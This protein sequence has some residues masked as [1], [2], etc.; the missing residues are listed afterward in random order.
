MTEDVLLAGL[1]EREGGFTN[2][3]ADRG[4]ATNFGITARELGEW[5][6]L[7]RA[8]TVAEVKA[9]T[10]SEA[11]DIYRRRYLEPFAAVPF[12]ELRAQ[13][14]DY[15]VNCGVVTAKRALQAVLRVPVDGVLGPRTLAAL[16]TLDWRLVNNG[17]VADRVKRYVGI[18]NEDATQKV[19]LLGWA[20]RA[21]EFLI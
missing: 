14:V 8:A 4:G 21:V 5:R 19:F 7:G 1:I 2:H 15:G 16:G 10:I 9:L 17:L 3:P 11:K 13:L 6:H 12:E 18:V 20:R